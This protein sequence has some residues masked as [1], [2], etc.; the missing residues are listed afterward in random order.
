MS[1]AQ[2]TYVEVEDNL[3]AARRFYN[4][5][6]NALNNA[7]QIFPGGMIATA[8]GVRSMPFFEVEEKATRQPVDAD[9]FLR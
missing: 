8:A 7:V 9:A 1:T 2:H 6:V 5:A 3:A 4:A